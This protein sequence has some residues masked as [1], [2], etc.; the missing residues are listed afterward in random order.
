M[1]QSDGLT[2]K[3]YLTILTNPNHKPLTQKIISYL[4]VEDLEMLGDVLE[5]S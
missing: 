1:E 4:S 3:I 2:V 5:K